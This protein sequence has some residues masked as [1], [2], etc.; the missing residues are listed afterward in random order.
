MFCFKYFMSSFRFHIPVK[1][2][3]T[4]IEIRVT[5]NMLLLITMAKTIKQF[6]NARYTVRN[7]SLIIEPLNNSE[8]DEEEKTLNYP[9]NM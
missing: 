4:P 9:K 2:F 3:F 7:S 6:C 1:H 8:E 5:Y